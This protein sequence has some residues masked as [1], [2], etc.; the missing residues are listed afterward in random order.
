ML[1]EMAAGG[2]GDRVAV[3]SLDDGLTVKQIFDHS[4]KAA[5]RFRDANVENVAMIDIT[6]PALPICLF[7]ASWAGSSSSPYP[8]SLS[9]SDSI[10]CFFSFLTPSLRSGI[11]MDVTT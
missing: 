8:S 4:G 2:F 3:G 7:G 6:S 9:E 5:K 11:L 1:L 10:T